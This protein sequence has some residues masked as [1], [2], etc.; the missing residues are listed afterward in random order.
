MAVPLCGDD[1]VTN[2]SMAW[3]RWRNSK[4]PNSLSNSYRSTDMKIG[5]YILDTQQLNLALVTRK[6]STNKAWA[7][8]VRI[9]IVKSLT[10]IEINCLIFQRRWKKKN[11]HT[12]KLKHLILLL[13]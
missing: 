1:L 4:V 8:N 3:T 6:S 7:Y 10:V 11:A 12:T 5:H 9:S 13:H 2:I